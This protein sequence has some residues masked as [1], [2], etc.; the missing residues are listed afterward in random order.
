MARTPPQAASPRHHQHA[1]ARRVAT[2]SGHVSTLAVLACLWPAGNA[3]AQQRTCEQWS[4]DITAVEGRVEVRRRDNPDLGRAHDRRAR[5]HRRRPAQPKLE[6]RDDHLAR[7][8]HL[9]ARREQRAGAPG[10]AFGTGLA[11]RVAPRRHSRHQPR[12]AVPP[13]QHALCQRRPRGNRVRHSRRREQPSHGDHRAR[14]RGRRFD[15]RGRAQRRERPCR[16]RE[17]RRS[18]AQ[19]HR[20][21]RRSNGCAGQATTRRSSIRRS[22]VQTK[23][24]PQP[25][26]TDAD[27]L[28]DPCGARA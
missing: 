18:A 6:P 24:R 21:L 10:A 23:S 25:S 16:A 19:R 14:R 2:T 5:L 26:E 15:A 12:P 11:G 13:V 7:R 9:A 27:L 3:H 1:A 28:R 20:T 17:R 4:A 22:P 8:R